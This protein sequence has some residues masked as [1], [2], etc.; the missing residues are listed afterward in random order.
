MNEKEHLLTILIEEMAEAQVSIC[1]SLRFGLD[2]GYPGSDTTNEEDL[3]KELV[4]V[5]AVL[6]ML[7]TKCYVAPASQHVTE[8]IMESKKRRVIEYMDYAKERGTLQCQ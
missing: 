1:K 5:C 6:E 2:D 3:M 4:E 7:I 8:E